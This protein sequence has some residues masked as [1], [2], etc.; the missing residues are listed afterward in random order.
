[1]KKSARVIEKVNKIIDLQNKFA[2][3]VEKTE[4]IKADYKQSLQELENLYGS[5]SKEAFGG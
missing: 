2:K 4:Q 5:L 1:L 3:I